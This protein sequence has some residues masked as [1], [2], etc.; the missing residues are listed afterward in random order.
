MS[1]LLHIDSSMK[2]EQSVSRSLNAR[3]REVWLAAGRSP[4]VT[5]G[6]SQSPTS[7]RSRALR[8]WWRRISRRRRRLRRGR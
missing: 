2:G 4:T 7:T 5:L 8:G 1:H 6:P 3:A